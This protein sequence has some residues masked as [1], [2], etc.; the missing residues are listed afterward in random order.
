MSA[1]PA[2]WPRV[3]GRATRS[4]RGYIG[5]VVPDSEQDLAAAAPGPDRD[6]AAWRRQVLIAAACLG[7]VAL[8]YV[9]YLRQSQTLAADADGASNVLQAWDMLHGNLLLSGWRLSDVSFYTTEL[10]EYMLA[11][12][13]RGLSPAVISTA[14][15]ATYTIL[16]VLTAMAARGR[17]C[18]AL[19]L[20]RVLV[21]AGIML[22]PGPGYG[23][24]SLLSSPDHTGTGV[25]LV[26]TWLAIDRL[27]GRRYL[28]WLAGALL[29]WAEIADQLAIYAGALPVVVVAVI[30]LARRRPTWRADAALLAAAAVSVPLGMGM[31]LLIRQAGGYTVASVPLTLATW[32]EVPGHLQLAGQSLLN[33]FGASFTGLT[34]W[35]EIVFAALHLAGLI[36]A[37]WACWLAAR[38]LLA[39]D[40]WLVPLLFTGIVI[41]LA[42]FT[43]STQAIDPGSTHELVA[44]LPFAAAL[45]GR[46]IPGRR[47]LTVLA[48]VLLVV[49]AGY[50][51]ALGWNAAGPAQPPAVQPVA[52]WLTAHRLTAGLGN[53]WIS[54]ITT[55]ATG[56]RVTVRPVVLSCGRF[57]PDAWE[58]RQS[59]YTPPATATFLVLSQ[60]A[61]SGPAQASAQFGAPEQTA[62]VGGYEVLIWRH[63]LLPALASGTA[64]GCGT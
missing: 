63:D 35:P 52:S 39:A 14:G 50:G 44:V 9:G 6:T 57:I 38:R 23:A 34:S 10:P 22:A 37:A 16:L 11:D 42:G 36:L 21:A 15:A 56:G 59:W 43:F 41:S 17:A 51:A 13:V 12:L 29:T 3:T 61:A 54:N 32:G 60:S 1:P 7:L 58:S 49:L 62:T 5:V 20:S 25:P 33:L 40:D 19:G 31:T 46:L 30:R 24:S 64:A 48:P 55:V 26:L 53:Y 4:R 2:Y 45:A 47:A 18:G 28:P 8:L 27:G